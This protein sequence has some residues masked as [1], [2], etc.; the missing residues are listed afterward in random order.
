MPAP[1]VG[2]AHTRGEHPALRGC[3]GGQRGRGYGFTYREYGLPFTRL[4]A[5]ATGT[6]FLSAIHQDCDAAGEN[7]VP[8]RSYYVTYEYEGCATSRRCAPTRTGA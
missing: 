7:C 6:R 3:C 1:R 4:E 2:A 5:D 8:Q